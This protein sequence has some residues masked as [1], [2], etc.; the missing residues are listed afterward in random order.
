MATP[1]V[2]AAPTAQVRALAAVVAV[3]RLVGQAGRLAGRLAGRPAVVLAGRLER[4]VAV[5]AAPVA[6]EVREGLAAVAVPPFVL[7]RPVGRGLLPIPVVLQGQGVRMWVD[8]TPHRTR[9]MPTLQRV[10]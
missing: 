6:L 3:A 5:Q 2:A 10:T 8:P 1:R 9:S 4:A 7:P